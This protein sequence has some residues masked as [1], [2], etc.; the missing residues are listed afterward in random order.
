MLQS[1]DLAKVYD[2]MHIKRRYKEVFMIID[3]CEAMSL[4]DSVSAPNLILLGTSIHDQSAYSHQFRHDLNNF[5]NDYFTYYF[6]KYLDEGHIGPD[7]KLSDFK[8]KFPISL[9]TS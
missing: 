5:L 1:E 4:F 2:E 9:I 7:F 6:Y 8:S 3:T